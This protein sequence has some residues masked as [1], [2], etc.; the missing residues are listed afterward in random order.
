MEEDKVSIRSLIFKLF[1]VD[2]S[3][4]LLGCDAVQCCRS[5]P[6]TNVVVVVVIQNEWQLLLYLCVCIVRF[7]ARVY[8]LNDSVNTFIFKSRGTRSLILLYTCCIQQHNKM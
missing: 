6:N 1:V 3:R 2:S 5:I 7:V 8:P 4:G